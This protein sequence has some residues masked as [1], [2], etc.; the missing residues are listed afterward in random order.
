MSSRVTTYQGHARTERGAWFRAA[1]DSSGT[2]V[3]SGDSGITETGLTLICDDDPDQFAKAAPAPAWT[4]GIDYT[5]GAL[6]TY[7]GIVYQVR[8]PHTSQTDW[9]PDT[10]LAL[11][12][13]VGSPAAADGAPPAWTT[14]TGYATGSHVTYQGSEYVCLQAHV[15]Q[16]DWMP[17]ATPALWSAYTPPSTTNAW[18]VGVAYAVGDLVTYQGA[19]YKCLQ[20]HTSIQTWNPAAA[21]SLWQLQ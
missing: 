5:D 14:S 4:T 3:W 15:S 17:P 11:F 16:S 18:A 9:P 8:Q 13:R 6:I 10:T 1:I 7:Q 12:L 21:G 19:T 2:V 20:A